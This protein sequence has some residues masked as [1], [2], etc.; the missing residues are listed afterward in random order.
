MPLQDKRVALITSYDLA[1]A[2]S[3]I[4]SMVAKQS[5]LLEKNY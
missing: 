4:L 2:I 3:I 5:L 1:D